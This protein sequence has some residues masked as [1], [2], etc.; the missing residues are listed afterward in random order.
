MPHSRILLSLVAAASL[1]AGCEQARIDQESFDQI[2]VG[3][4]YEEVKSILGG[5]GA[6]ETPSGTSISGAG[7]ASGSGSAEKLYVWK[8][9][10]RS[11]AVNIKDGK[12]TNVTKF[13]F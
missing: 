2:K 6:D 5:D 1:L 9:K 3:M 4:S 13:G 11:I 7:V 8:D 10:S 12:V